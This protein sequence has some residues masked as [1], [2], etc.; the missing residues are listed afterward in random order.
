MIGISM[1][2]A[3]AKRWHVGHLAAQSLIVGVGL[4]WGASQ[5]GAATVGS[6]RNLGRSVV[7]AD[8]CHEWRGPGVPTPDSSLTNQM[9]SD[10]VTQYRIN[11]HEVC[12]GMTAVAVHLAWGLPRVIR[13]TITDDTTV[14]RYEYDNAELVLVD[15][16]VEE[17]H[18][19]ERRHRGS[20]RQRR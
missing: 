14:D 13:A 6:A 4:V 1:S 10:S 17:V 20:L 19:K 16:I 8:K 12:V 15:G 7:T 2:V 3:T 9:P 18:E 5:V 11:R